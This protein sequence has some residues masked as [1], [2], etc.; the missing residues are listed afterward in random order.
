[1][2]CSIDMILELQGE[3]IMT[4]IEKRILHD[5]TNNESKVKIFW[6]MDGTCA[7]MEMHKKEHKL[8]PGFFFEKRPIKTIIQVMENFHRLGAET[9]I[10]S[11]CGYNY[12]RVD[13]TRWLQIYC[14]FIDVNNIIIIPRR[15]KDIKSSETKQSLK[16]EYLKEY[17]TD[18][19]LVYMI[20]DNESVLLGTKE[21]LP[22]INIVSP[23]DFIE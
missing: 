1:M 6:D 17:V 23:I 15:E 10:L 4:E 22:F 19:D 12:Q 20:D 18:T 8:E 16:A 2:V 9:Y 13:K 3:H 5:I 21:K 7:S 14:D 11:F